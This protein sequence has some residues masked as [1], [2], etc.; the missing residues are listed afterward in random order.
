M[1]ERTASWGETTPANLSLIS[2]AKKALPPGLCLTFMVAFAYVCNNAAIFGSVPDS[3][4]SSA[5][6]NLVTVFNALNIPFC[7][8][9]LSTIEG[10]TSLANNTVGLLPS[11]FFLKEG[12]PYV[13]SK[14]YPLGGLFF[15]PDII[16]TSSNVLLVKS[17]RVNGVPSTPCIL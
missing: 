16:N 15:A 9:S 10:S 6:N 12:Y 4:F 8:A 1:N 3:M 13:G 11:L 17:L 5:Y 7:M 14:G 2:V